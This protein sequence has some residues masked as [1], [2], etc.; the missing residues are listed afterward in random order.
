MKK[1]RHICINICYCISCI[2]EEAPFR[3]IYRPQQLSLCRVAAVNR[4]PVHRYSVGIVT[5]CGPLGLLRSDIRKQNTAKACFFFFW[6]DFCFTAL[7]HIL[8]HF[9]RGQLT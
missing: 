9:G 7:Q 1:K 8:G 2:S 6:F 3:I 5:F 4:L